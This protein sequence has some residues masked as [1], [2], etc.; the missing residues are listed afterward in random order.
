MSIDFVVIAEQAQAH[1]PGPRLF[2]HAQSVMGVTKED[3]IHVAMGQF[4]DL[5]VRR[6]L[7]IRSVWVD[8]L[9]EAAPGPV[10]TADAVLLD[11]SGLPEL[12]LRS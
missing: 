11:L 6:E 7:D 10:W 9:G 8:R 1:K 5:K 4:T 12:L 2:R 3:T